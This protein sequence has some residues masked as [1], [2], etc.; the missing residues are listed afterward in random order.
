VL[1]FLGLQVSRLIRISYGPFV[2]GDMPAGAV[3]EVKQHDLV[4]FRKTLK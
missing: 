3:N 2:L 4:A 1:E